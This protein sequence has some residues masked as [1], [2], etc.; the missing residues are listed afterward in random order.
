M[1]ERKKTFYGFSFLKGGKGQPSTT[2][3]C[4]ETS[5]IRGVESASIQPPA[6]QRVRT[7]EHRWEGH[8]RQ[9]DVRRQS[10]PKVGTDRCGQLVIREGAV[11][12]V[13]E[14]EVA[15]GGKL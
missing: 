6:Q 9:T 12:K 13:V 14:V 15:T 3:R 2:Q 4:G 1:I 8:S 11:W 5:A 7:G 10:A